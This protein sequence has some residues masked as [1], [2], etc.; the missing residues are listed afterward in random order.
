MESRIVC[1]T[2]HVSH[3]SR[4]TNSWKS[5]WSHLHPPISLT[6]G[7]ENCLIAF[8]QF[9]RAAHQRLQHYC[10]CGFHF[11]LN[12]GGFWDAPQL[13][14]CGV[15]VREDC[16]ELAM[17][18]CWNAVVQ[19]VCTFVMSECEREQRKVKKSNFNKHCLPVGRKRRI[20]NSYFA[21]FWMASTSLSRT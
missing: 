14:C 8:L 3:I 17:T 6:R 2:T 9:E 1:Y 16:T 15:P 21:M 5:T 11:H 12:C 19:P 4:G 7:A 10:W 18:R 20:Q 13:S